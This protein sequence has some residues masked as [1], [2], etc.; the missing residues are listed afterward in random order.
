MILKDLL[1]PLDSRSSASMFPVMPF[2]SR[3]ATTSAVVVSLWS[4]PTN[5]HAD[6][7]PIFRRLLCWTFVPTICGFLLA[8]ALSAALVIEGFSLLPRSRSFFGS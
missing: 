1:G 2:S 7:S 8:V 6:L 3:Y 4:F 5:S